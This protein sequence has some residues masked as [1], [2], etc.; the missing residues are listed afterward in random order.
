LLLAIGVPGVILLGRE[1]WLYASAHPLPTGAAAAL[2]MVLAAGAGWLSI[3]RRWRLRRAISGTNG[4]T[5]REFECYVAELMRRT[6]FRAVRVTGRTADLGADI[7][8]ST[9]D[10]RRVVVQCKRYAGNV[11]SPHV[12]RLNGTAWTIH[13]ADVTMLVT[14]GR[15][16]ANARDLAGRCGIVLVDRHALAAWAATGN[17][18]LVPVA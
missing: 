8:A 9:A 6:G 4:M 17:L 2:I 16:T 15:L 10:G 18:G 7:I 1:A 14:T 12:Q 11:G 5:G 13:R 3:R